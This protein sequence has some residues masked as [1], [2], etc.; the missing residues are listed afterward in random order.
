M[1]IVLEGVSLIVVRL[2]L[3]AEYLCILHL[4]RLKSIGY[5]TIHLIPIKFWTYRQPAYIEIEWLNQPSSLDSTMNLSS[6]LQACLR[7]AP[8]ASCTSNKMC[9]LQKAD[10][11]PCFIDGNDSHKLLH[12]IRYP[13]LLW[14]VW[15]CLCECVYIA[16]LERRLTNTRKCADKDFSLL[17]PSLLSTLEI[18]QSSLIAYCRCCTFSARGSCKGTFARQHLA[19]CLNSLLGPTSKAVPGIKNMSHFSEGGDFV[20]ISWISEGSVILT[21]VSQSPVSIDLSIDL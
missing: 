12:V 2:C 13:H 16:H 21:K 19:L 4:E 20:Y 14:C 1:Y 5:L 10:H 17:G 6:Y 8:C 3:Q 15:R 11:L 9:F 7:L 18:C